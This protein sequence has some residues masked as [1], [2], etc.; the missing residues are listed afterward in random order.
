VLVDLARRRQSQ[1]R[2][3]GWNRTTLSG[4]HLTDEAEEVDLVELD[5]ALR[6]LERFD[7]RWHR[8][9]ELRFF[10]GLSGEETA[11]LLGVSRRTVSKEWTMA[12]AFLR[13]ELTS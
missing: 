10:A 6:K 3:Q 2:G 4:V 12:K 9:V 1:K 13:R 7:E 5:Q 11:S 8:V